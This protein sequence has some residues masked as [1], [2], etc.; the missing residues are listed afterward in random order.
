LVTG[1][2]VVAIVAM[3]GSFVRRP[4]SSASPA[5]SYIVEGKPQ[6]EKWKMSTGCKRR[7]AIL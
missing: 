4:S 2:G 6:K 1:R 7:F 5:R 3:S